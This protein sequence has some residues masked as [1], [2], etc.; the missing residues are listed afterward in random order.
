[1]DDKNRKDENTSRE[2]EPESIAA[3]RLKALGEDAKEEEQEEVK[4]DKLANFWYHYKFRIIM[5]A[6]FAFIII[7][8]TAQFVS[9]QNPDINIIYGGPQYITPNQN[10]AFCEVLQSMIPDYN[11]DGK[12]YVQL[13]D[14]VFMSE[15]QVNEYLE[16]A[17]ES[18][19]E[20]SINLLSNKQVSERFTYEIFGGESVICILAEDQYKAVA[21][22]G[23]FLPLS[24]LF[25]DELPEGAIDGYGVRF[26]ET[27][28]CKFYDSAKIFPDDAVIAL[29]RLSTM[30]AFT[31]KK[32]AERKYEY[33]RDLFITMMNFEYP[34]GYVPPE[35]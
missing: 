6:A 21:A 29:R 18:G 20:V 12:K 11:G 8:A 14:M 13:N 2:E 25:G 17:K 27:K 1:M 15:N 34:E 4:V 7:V 30:S 31:G 24:E 5:I 33:H 28:L 19:E 22:E 23:G 10:K 32:K 9:R 3:K 35:E 26:C 16:E